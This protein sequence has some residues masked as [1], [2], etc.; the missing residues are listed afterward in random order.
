MADSTIS[1]TF[2]MKGTVHAPSSKAHTHRALV[3]GLLSEGL[4]RIVN[5]LISNDT[6]ATL[7]AIKALGAAARLEKNAW[8]IE[9]VAEVQPSSKPIDCAESGATLRFLVPVAALAKGV[10]VFVVGHSLEIRP[11]QPLLESMGQLGAETESRRTALG[12]ILQVRGGGIK[13]GKTKIRGDISSQFISG[14]L[15]A[16]PKAMED[17]EI[18]LTTPLESKDYVEI[19]LEVLSMHGVEVKHSAD[20]EEFHVPSHQIFRACNHEIPGDFSSAAFMLAA[21]AV[22][23]SRIRVENLNCP[24]IQADREILVTLATMGSTITE[25]AG[26]VQIE[27]KVKHSIDIECVNV[28]DLV[29]VY[30]VLACYSNGL[31]RI[32]N[33]GRLRYKE[34]N[35]LVSLCTELTKM[36]ADISANDDGLLIKGR[37]KL[38]GARIDPR[39]DHRIAMACS[40]AA[41]GAT[42][43]TI[44]QNSECIAKSYPRFFDDLRSLGAEI[45]V[46]KFDR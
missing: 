25:E 9:G 33:A 39:N 46:G 30:A 38:H 29:P 22:T 20:F 17:V 32:R 8:V 7:E 4:T 16:A 31:S 34:S 24:T 12:S 14:L 35:R 41:L 2:D 42:G 3:A 21:A 18:R 11:M 37:C 26:H 1:Q 44:I 5:P 36:G 6:L 40:I 15:F 28:P 43:E 19:T 13:G 27:G 10:S 23:S 45:S